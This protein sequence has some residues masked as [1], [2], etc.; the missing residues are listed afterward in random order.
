MT[1]LS[2]T[3]RYCYA[4]GHFLNDVCASMWFTYLLLFFKKVIGLTNKEASLLFLVGQCTDGVLTPAISTAIDKIRPV[5]FYPHRKAWH[6]LGTILVTMSFT[7]ILSKPVF[8]ITGTVA[9]YLPFVMI[10]QVG[11]AFTQLSHLS[12][13]PYL[14]DSDSDRADLNSLRYGFFVLANVFVYL[15]AYVIFQ[16]VQDCTINV[17]SADKFTS[18]SYG[19]VGLGAIMAVAFHAVLKEKEQSKSKQTSE[20]EKS[21]D[22]SATSLILPTAGTDEFIAKAW[23]DW[24]K[25]PPMYIYAMVFLMARLSNNTLQAYL[26]LYITDTIQLA[27]SYIA[28]LPFVQYIFGLMAALG[29]KVIADKKGTPIAYI[30]GCGLILTACLWVGLMVSNIV[31]NSNEQIWRFLVIFALYGAGCNMLVCAAYGLIAEFIG[32][33][34]KYSAFVYGIMSFGDKIINGLVVV[35]LESINTCGKE[36]LVE[37]PMNSTT[38]GEETGPLAVNSTVFADNSTVAAGLAQEAQ[39]CTPGADCNFYGVFISRGT[40]SFVMTGLA[41]L[42]LQK[43]LFGL[44]TKKPP[45]PESDDKQ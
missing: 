5:S 28:M 13:I 11:W 38:L 44:N 45:T 8:G 15:V 29:T 14:A 19:S 2:R 12:L 33:N 26:T 25:H 18:I 21:E 6:L 3:Q 17:D 36:T 22:N 37:S 43:V 7:F 30:L 32:R 34:V 39:A 40:A 31:S 9:Y 1:Q 27:P 35:V 10:F 41:F 16:S 42:T 20:T 4:S 24:F 23:Y